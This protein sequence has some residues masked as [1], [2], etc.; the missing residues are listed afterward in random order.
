[1]P[2]GNNAEKFWAK[3]PTMSSATF[4]YCWPIWKY[5]LR[6]ESKCNEIFITGESKYCYM[7]FVLFF[8]LFC[9]IKIFYNKKLE[10]NKGMIALYLVTWKDIHS[11]N[12]IVYMI[13]CIR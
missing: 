11:K 5:I 1:M 3:K 7:V 10:E 9:R 2:L 4:V 6:G 8:Q 13:S 12:K